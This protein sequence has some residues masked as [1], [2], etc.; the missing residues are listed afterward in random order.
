MLKFVAFQALPHVKKRQVGAGPAEVTAIYCLEVRFHDTYTQLFTTM[1]A[2]SYIFSIADPPEGVALTPELFFLPFLHEFAQFLYFLHPNQDACP[3]V[4]CIVILKSRGKMQWLLGTSLG[5]FKPD[6]ITYWD[7]ELKSGLAG[8]RWAEMAR[9]LG[10]DPEMVAPLAGSAEGYDWGH[11]AES[12]PFA[13]F[14]RFVACF[15]L[16]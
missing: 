5:R 11:C 6:D 15:G 8:A 12:L 13:C 10:L 7:S 3:K 16:R 1:D 9:L 4:M 2:V 14:L